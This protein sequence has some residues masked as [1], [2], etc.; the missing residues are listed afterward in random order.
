MIFSALRQG[1]DGSQLLRLFA[2]V[3]AL[4]Y[5]NRLGNVDV[6]S[7][8]LKDWGHVAVFFL[9]SAMLL[10]QF[11]RWIESRASQRSW[12]LGGFVVL[13][14]SIGAGIELVQ[15][16]F[17]RDRSLTDWIYD[18]AGVSAALLLYLAHGKQKRMWYGAAMVVLGLSAI[19]PAYYGWMVVARTLS[20]PYL[21]GFE[22]L[23]ERETWLA[24]PNSV[25]RIVTS[26]AE[27]APNSPDEH[28]LRVEMSKGNYPGVSFPR[29]HHDWRGYDALAL[30]IF[31][32]QTQP[33]KLVMRIHDVHH[34]N[35]FNDRYNHTFILQ[36][37]LN[38]LAISLRDIAS[39]PKN[40][41]MDLSN[42]QNIMLFVASPEQPVTLYIDNLR[43]L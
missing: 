33:V 19:K 9:A 27:I 38:D 35:D 5:F 42:I 3:C 37:G 1:L 14:L 4:I 39:A 20:A 6:F 26:P 41:D 32:S 12:I 7:S 43:L 24:Q 40:R 15:P 30:R 31:S 17:G 21:A 13:C 29:I 8:A 36:P 22:H 23:W 16:W 34:N 28:W 25:V 11:R 18:G 2:L 10:H